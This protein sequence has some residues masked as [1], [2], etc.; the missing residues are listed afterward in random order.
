MLTVEE[1]L[2]ALRAKMAPLGLHD[3]LVPSADEHLNEYLPE[4][5]KRREFLTGF[6]GSAGDFL[7]SAKDAWLYADG[8]YHLQA[9]R[10]V[11]GSGISVMKVG[12][13]ASRPLLAHVEERCGLVQGY[14][15][16]VDPMTIPLATAEALEERLER[17]GG[18]LVPVEEN[19]VDGLWPD[20]PK[21]STTP[22][23]E[24]DSTWTGA[25]TASKLDVIRKDLRKSGASA[26]VV[27]KLDQIAWLLNLRGRDD[28]PYNP[29]FESFLIVRDDRFQLFLHGKTA[30]LP[31][32]FVEKNAG[33][34]VYEIGQFPAMLQTVGEQR[35]RVA[36][37]P[38]STTWGVFTLLDAHGAEILRVSSP[39]EERKA[40]KNAAEQEAQRRAN[41][42]ASVAKT[43]AILWL[44]RQIAAGETVTEASF[45]TRIEMHYAEQEGFFG[46]SFNTIAATGAHGAIIHYGACDETPL[47]LGDLF[48]I[49]SGAH[50][51]GGTT[52]DTRTVAVGRATPEARKLYTLVLKG[53]IAAARQRIPEGAPG[54]ALDALAR[55]A[56]WNEGLNYDH[57]TG[58]GV[59]AFLNV[60]EG[61]FAI[62]ERDRKPYSGNPLKEGIVS[63]IEP[64]YYR[65]GFGGIRLEN[66]YLYV[67]EKSSDARIWLRLEP[68]TYIPFDPLLTDDALL[69]PADRA[70][71]DA[72]HADCIEKLSPLLPETERYE[73]RA[74]LR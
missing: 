54:S 55:S 23:L 18:R 11:Q 64:G 34:E 15:L 33:L 71:L 10:E 36:I 28:I 6:T 25:S 51:A 52:D 20:A 74:L 19:L 32:G 8:R 57:G 43:R 72:Y 37:D 35:A 2:R 38:S 65:E 22:L 69:D 44:R 60:H 12:A 56:L 58:H 68:L 24:L 3:Y 27:V 50:I 17:H 45:R 13:P 46:L 39:I 61:P 73:L 26:F 42:R 66:L 21:P 41:L 47:A 63:S 9:E 30:R 31:A 14:A 7:V 67:R 70:W 53:H 4:R 49:D 29:V 62:S 48:L 1:K 59:G 40:V 5:R 16:G